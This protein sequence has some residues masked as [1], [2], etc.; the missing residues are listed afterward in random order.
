MTPTVTKSGPTAVAAP[1][2][3]F[4]VHR[5]EMWKPKATVIVASAKDGLPDVDEAG[6]HVLA[7]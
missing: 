5:D 1:P 4:E 3:R 6:V 7:R 2:M